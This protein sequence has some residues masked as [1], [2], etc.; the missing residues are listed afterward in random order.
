MRGLVFFRT[1]RRDR[2]VE[3]YRGRLGADEWLD[4]PA[5]CTIL[6]FGTLLVGFCDAATAETEGTITLAVENRAAVDDRYAAL[7]D[8]ARGPPERNDDFGI[9]QFFLD[10]P[11]GRTVEIQAFLGDVPSVP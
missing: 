1:A 8:L 9:Y 6:R 3:F 2:L 11:E 7:R 5:G 10:D 4:Q